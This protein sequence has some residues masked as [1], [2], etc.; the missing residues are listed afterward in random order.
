[1]LFGSAVGWLRAAAVLT[2]VGVLALPMT[3]S[4]DA[5]PGATQV[6]NVVAVDAHG[7]PVNG[8]HVVNRQASPNLSGCWGPSPAAVGTD[9]YTCQP[10]QAAAEVCWPA[11]A[12]VLCL[13][14]PWSKAFAASP[15]R[16]RSQR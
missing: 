10:R 3:R 13:I 6:V 1:M 7:A 4:A 9:V 14:E 12:T 15:P 8:Y 2:L 16:S 11:R 5:D